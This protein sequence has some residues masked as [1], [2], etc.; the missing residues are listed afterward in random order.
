M[1]NLKIAPKLAILVGVALIGLC[2]S[3]VIAG[4]LMKGE[5]YDARVHQTKAIVTVARNMALELKKEVDAG[6]ITKDQ[7]MNLFRKLGNA[8]SY[9]NGRAI[10]TQRPMTASPSSRQIPSR[11]APTA[12]K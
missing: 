11:S 5:L 6:E 7:A 1:K 3:G 2:V 4:Y 8:M 10:C 12:W 9:D